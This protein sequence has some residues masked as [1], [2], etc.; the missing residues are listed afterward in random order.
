MGTKPDQ[1]GPV[2][3][4]LN[5][6]RANPTGRLALR[7]CIGVLGT[8]VIGLGLV[9]IPLPGPGWAIVILG[10]AI[11]ALEFRWARSLLHFT[12]RHVQAWTKWVVRQSVPVRILLGAVGLMFVAMVVWASV[13]VTF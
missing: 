9:L 2:L 13:R 7:I 6:V 12:R 11:W 8:L 4:V 10:L 1:G 3:G 5:R